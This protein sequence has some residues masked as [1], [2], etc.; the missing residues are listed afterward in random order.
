MKV[1]DKVKIR[2]DSQFYNDGW[3]NNPVGVVGVITSLNGSGAK[4]D[5]P[6]DVAW[7][8]IDHVNDYAEADLEVVK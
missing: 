3:F 6:I 1:G 7:P 5:L 8:G 2:K 4:Q